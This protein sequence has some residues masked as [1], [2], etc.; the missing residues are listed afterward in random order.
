MNP[1]INIKNKFLPFRPGAQTELAQYDSPKKQLNEMTGSADSFE[2]RKKRH[3]IITKINGVGINSKYGKTG[4]I[5][6]QDSVTSVTHLP[7][8][9]GP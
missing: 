9:I 8:V 1:K 6:T 4:T 5:I 2:S 3:S 7:S